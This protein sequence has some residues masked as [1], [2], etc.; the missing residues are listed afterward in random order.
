M[1][2]MKK[3]IIILFS[4]LLLAVST[5]VVIGV[6]YE[7]EVKKYLV[8]E[9]NKQLNTPV[10]IDSKGIHFSILKHFPYASLEFKNV[11]ILEAVKKDNRDTLLK[12]SSVSLQFNIIDI[13]RKNYRIKKIELKDATLSIKY[14]AEGKN[15]YHFW[16]SN[17]SDT[18][19][20]NFSV[21]IEK[22]TLKNVEV[23][24]SDDASKLYS[25]IAIEKAIMTGSFSSDQ[26][27]LDSEG[28]LFAKYFKY[29]GVNYVDQK[30]IELSLNLDVDH[31]SYRTK[32][33]EIKIADLDFDVSGDVSV[34][35]NYNVLNL[36]IKGSDMNIATVL[37]IL[38]DKYRE[39]LKDY[40]SDGDFYFEST[41]KGKMDDKNYPVIKAKFGMDEVE[42][43][44]SE[45]DIAL[46]NIYL[47]G[48]LL[49]NNSREELVVDTFSTRLRQGA[50]KGSF[51]ISNFSDPYLSGSFDADIDLAEV[52]KFLAIDTLESMS[53]KAKLNLK[54]SGRAN[55]LKKYSVEEL[56]QIK[57]SGQM[58]ITDLSLRIK[59]NSLL[60][61][62]LNGS[63]TFDN[64][65]VVVNDFS[66]K[67]SESDF[68]L[69]GVLKNI[70]PYYFADN[71]Q[72]T[73]NAT[74]RSA[75]INLNE[76]LQDKEVETTE[77]TVY[78][79]RFPPLIKFNLEN[80]VGQISFRNFEAQNIKGIIKLDGERLTSDDVSFSTMDGKISITNGVI[81]ATHKNQI[82][83]TC[84]A[85]LKR[86]NINKMFTQLENFG[87]D[88][89][90]DKNLK[91]IATADIQFVSIC[92][93]DLEVDLDKVY[94]RS[95][96]TIEK[97]ELINFEY[98]KSLSK[99]I[100]VSELEHVKFSTLQ[101]QI[102]IKNQKIYIPKMEINS[103]ALNI[104][105][106]G[107]H[108]FN[109]DIDYKVKLLLNDLLA[110]KARKAKKENDEF[111]VIE[112]D[113][114]GKTALYLSM[115]GSV[116]DPVIKYDRKSAVQTIKE[117][118]K[119]AKQNLKDILKE[120]FGWFKKDSL[121][122][123]KEESK[124]DGKF[125]IKWDEDEEQDK[126]KQA[127][128]EDEDF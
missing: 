15:N 10:I 72:L 86:I 36:S 103:S 108:T 114:L 32:K 83:I 128:E 9:I 79:L 116:Y 17:P 120:E 85:S 117:D 25:S 67:I 95:N 41:I 107:T 49:K 40:E 126:K 115:T 12:A 44:Y 101:N 43:V 92:S 64:S 113:G 54:Y 16:K 74:L 118:F 96:V 45:K 122:T 2:M 91:G 18:A 29:D 58:L 38:P 62:S 1:K 81:D 4:A 50:V 90:I 76:I 110:K 55:R 34:F 93:P 57:A 69:K 80:E 87:Q 73:V 123:K 8:G 21:A 63:F 119:A 104:S 127:E 51:R 52:K 89:I 59:G 125:I 71:E 27:S 66:G 70:F 20:S 124:K 39:S 84:D 47:K 13:F 68:V 22:I 75:K 33:S 46:D 37:S 3:S 6:Y 65:D 53:G 98:L 102:E 106:S 82:L 94:V 88:V 23:K 19:N 112:D 7:D 26:Y 121:N 105:T 24:Y 35:E 56:K 14:D 109:N 5:A 77:D 97:G 111:G 28:K 48:T 30:S 60:F 42:I 11:R 31:D 99:F 61:D 100:K 78:A